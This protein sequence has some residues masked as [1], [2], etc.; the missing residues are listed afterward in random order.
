MCLSI[1]VPVTNPT[2]VT[3]HAVHVSANFPVPANVTV[4][5]CVPL[6]FAVPSTVS[7]RFL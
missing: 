4:P 1:H 5:D 7:V 3:V 6:I 2:H